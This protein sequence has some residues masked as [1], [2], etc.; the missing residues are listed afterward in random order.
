MKVNKIQM[1]IHKNKLMKNKTLRNNYKIYKIKIV[2]EIK[3][4]Q[5]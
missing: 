5:K 4:N 2:I 1:K 3:H